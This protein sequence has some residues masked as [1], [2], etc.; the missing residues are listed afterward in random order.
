RHVR[1]G[2]VD[3]LDYIVYCDPRAYHTLTDDPARYELARVIGKLNQKLADRRFILMGPGRWGSN[4]T[5]LGIPVQYSEISNARALIEIAHR[6]GDYT[7]EVSF[8][9]HFFLDLVE[10]GIHY[11]P[12]FPDD[13]DN[14]FQEEFFRKTPNA[15]VSL[16]PGAEAQAPYVKVIEANQ[17]GGGR[18][19]QLRMSGRKKLAVAYFDGA[20]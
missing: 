10:K 15:L 14:T 19:L 16:L 5:S 12:L 18:P 2:R 1:N 4:N 17:A 13:K 11:L 9:T 20:A 6:E 8:G 7:P 3:R